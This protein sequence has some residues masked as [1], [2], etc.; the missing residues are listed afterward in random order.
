MLIWN[1]D[2]FGEKNWTTSGAPSFALN[3]MYYNGLISVKVLTQLTAP[4]ATAP[5][6]IMCFA[7]AADNIEFAN[8]TELP[9]PI[10]NLSI[11]SGREEIIPMSAPMGETH[12]IEVDRTRI[13]FG[14]NIR[15]LRQLLRRSALNETYV[16]VDTNN[17]LLQYGY[18]RMTRFPVPFGYANSGLTQVVGLQNPTATY[19]F[20]A[21]RNTAYNWVALAFIGQRGSMHL[22]FNAEANGPVRQFTFSRYNTGEG[23]VARGLNSNAGLNKNQASM[24]YLQTMPRSM[25]G[26]AITNQDTCAGLS[27]SMPHMSPY[28]FQSTNPVNITNPPNDGT[29]QGDG[30]RDDQGVLTWSLANTTGAGQNGQMKIHKY[31]GCGTDFNLH[32]FLCTPT[33]IN[34]INY[35]SAAP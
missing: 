1:T 4:V 24:F 7:R 10:S 19:N 5:V 11:Q 8:P 28:K 13:N 34:Y 14:E 9:A 25:A 16:T 31:V 32:Y 33:F 6:Q 18:W 12:E 21:T 23:Q 35:P 17:Q 15:S 30:S 29:N 20:N 2:L 3:D 22:T 27:V 26:T